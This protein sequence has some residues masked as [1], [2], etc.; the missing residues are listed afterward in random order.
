MTSVIA[1][2]GPEWLAERCAEGYGGLLCS[3]CDPGYT[4]WGSSECRRCRNGF[5][6]VLFAVLLS[7][8]V[9][10]L[11]I[12]LVLKA[13]RKGAL[14]AQGMRQRKIGARNPT[15]T[16]DPVSSVRPNPLV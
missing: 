14:A 5:V 2:G 16:R 15:G 6:L 3:R 8:G 12:G 7:L 10:L 4:P 9:L 11:S 1:L 13:L